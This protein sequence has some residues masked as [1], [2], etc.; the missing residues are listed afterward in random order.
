MTKDIFA[1]CIIAAYHA[2]IENGHTM[3]SGTMVLKDGEKFSYKIRK[4]ASRKKP[5][6]SSKK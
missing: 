6:E 3:E 4:L 5:R 1:D 2:M